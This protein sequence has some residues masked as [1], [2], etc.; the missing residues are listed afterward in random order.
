MVPS[1][2]R[3]GFERGSKRGGMCFWGVVLD[4]IKSDSMKIQLEKM[5]F[6]LSYRV[7]LVITSLLGFAWV[8]ELENVIPA[9]EFIGSSSCQDHLFGERVRSRACP[10]RGDRERGLS[11]SRSAGIPGCSPPGPPHNDIAPLKMPVPANNDAPIEP[12]KPS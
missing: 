1:P 12:R 8:F 9:N 7:V 11:L 3:Q 5:F 10:C 6:V 4:E 2:Q